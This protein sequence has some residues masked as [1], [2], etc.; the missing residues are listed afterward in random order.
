MT[1][2]DNKH[3]DNH[4]VFGRALKGCYSEMLSKRSASK[5]DFELRFQSALE[6]WSKPRIRRLTSRESSFEAAVTTVIVVVATFAVADS[7]AR[8][9][10][11]S[12]QFSGDCGS[13]VAC[14]LMF[15][16]YTNSK[17]FFRVAFETVASNKDQRY[18]L[19]PSRHFQEGFLS[20]FRS[21]AQS[22]IMIRFSAWTSS[23]NQI[24]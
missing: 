8:R 2:E 1:S 7:E 14:S 21:I 23:Q 13:C 22:R 4:N 20:V 15:L 3:G 9:R 11:H 17:T 5:R 12:T 18:V 16:M 10:W 6:S 24:R 19:I